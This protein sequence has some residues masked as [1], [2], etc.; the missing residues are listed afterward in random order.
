[1]AT[2]ALSVLA[3]ATTAATSP[4]STATQPAGT[5]DED[6][7]I[8]ASF[9][10]AIW[11]LI[12]PFLV[13]PSAIIGARLLKYGWK[14][15]QAKKYGYD[16]DLFEDPLAELG[17]KI[18]RGYEN[19]S[20]IRK[21]RK[22]QRKLRAEMHRRAKQNE[23]A[24]ADNMGDPSGR[25]GKRAQGLPRS[26]ST[27]IAGSFVRNILPIQAAETYL[28]TLRRQTRRTWIDKLSPDAVRRWFTVSRFARAWMVFQVFCTVLAI[29]NYVMLTYLVHREDRG[30]RKLI[31]NLD[32][33]YAAV[34]LVDYSLSFY[35]AEDRLRFYF[36]Y[37]SLV[38]LVSIVSPFVF[39][40]VASDT[41]FVWFVGLIRIFL[42]RDAE[43]TAFI[44][45]F[46]NFI[47][48]SASVINATETLVMQWSAP[49]SLL[50]W[51][52]SLYYIMVTF[53]TIGFGDLTPT[54]TISRIITGKILELYNSLSKYQRAAHQ[55]SS[56]SPHVILSG[57]VT[58][59]GL[60]DFCREYFISDNV[61]TIV[62]LH[63]EEPNIDIRRLLNHPFYRNRL[64]YLRGNLMSIPDLRRAAAQYATGMFL[65]NSNAA[66]GSG[67]GSSDVIDE[68]EE[69]KQTRGMDAQVLMQALVAKNG[70]PGLPIFA[71]VQD[72]RSKELSGH[73]GCDRILCIDEI[74]MSLMAAN[75]VVP[76]I[77]TLI[78]NLIHSYRELENSTLPE[79]W[80][81]EYQGG[82]ANQVYSFKVPNGLV[83]MKF[84]DA[85]AEVYNSYGTI[86]I[87]LM[88]INA[89][90]NQNPVRMSMDRDYRIKNDDIAFCM[91]TGGDE[92]VLRICIHFKEV[93]KKYELDR[94]D[95]EA[96]MS[97][98]INVKENAHSAFGYA[99]SP[100]LPS[101][102]NTGLGGGNFRA[103]SSN[104]QEMPQSNSYENKVGSI[105]AGL[106]GHIVLCGHITARAV[107]Q[108]VISL[109]GVNHP[110]GTTA[111]TLSLMAA[112]ARRVP[113]VC[114]VETL[115]KMD[116]LGVWSD[117]LSYENVFIVQGTAIKRTS[118]L[119]AGVS[120]CARIVILAKPDRKDSSSSAN[121][122]IADG[123]SLF[124][125][126]MLQREWPRVR[127]LV[128]LIDGANVKYFS[129]R[130]LE[131]DTHNM[132]IQAILSNY[133]LSISDRL[134]LYRK[135]RTEHAEQSTIWYQLVQ[136]VFG[137]GDSSSSSQNQG[138]MVKKGKN[139][140][141][142]EGKG[143]TADGQGKT[144]GKRGFA[145]RSYTSASAMKPTTTQG[146][147]D[148]LKSLR[149]DDI[150]PDGEEDDEE[151]DNGGIGMSDLGSSSN[152]QA[153]PTDAGV[154]QPSEST[155]ASRA[156]RVQPDASPPAR[157]T[158]GTAT[159]D[160]S[161]KR[162][163]D[164]DRQGNTG[165]SDS[166]SESETEERET[167]PEVPITEAYLQRLLEEAEL[168]ESGLSPYPVYHFDRHFAAG[169]VS[170]S[171]FIHSLLC[172][173][174][175]RPYIV[176]VVRA[177]ILSVIHLPV[178]QECVN[179]PY[180]HAVQYYLAAGYVPI[181]LYR[182]GAAAE[183]AAADAAIAASTIMTSPMSDI[184][185]SATASTPGSATKPR[186][187][188]NR[189]SE[190]DNTPYVYTN[191][192][193]SDIVNE[194]DLIFA[195]RKGP[196]K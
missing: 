122:S 70:F 166:D 158:N 110:D 103:D 92:T 115:P 104:F 45:N 117:I 109:R 97:R 61:G 126:K 1:M 60:V 84:Y 121:N 114:L 123:N 48:F 191:C 139:R 54:S 183:Q 86:I 125:V 65:L 83:G 55:A 22:E 156:Q 193:P 82:V 33:L 9:D 24:L 101:L 102:L 159:G 186:V 15:Y 76:G 30:Q 81:Q 171:S 112:P 170:T 53:S 49:P 20:E 155:R 21:I 141:K 26:T 46:L 77:Q 190:S 93:Y 62:V 69:L 113:V 43:L 41:K 34:F 72:V 75:C 57:S 47:F 174:Y 176:D 196:S 143:E 38:D 42:R 189:M 154:S 11:A 149:A 4:A 175:M 134:E 13:I 66:E 27:N 153:Q 168:N 39:V 195:I 130:N 182:R 87:A 68:A 32:L 169:M 164:A 165:D 40:L 185:F 37:T 124:I 160:D 167:K 35:I 187:G 116:D 161:A 178:S 16:D 177:L 58:P 131:W 88:S 173:S 91:S 150:F 147:Y 78:L 18:R 63:T 98:V 107:R 145:M 152:A 108:F 95:L 192:R 56:S 184:P 96:E 85:A 163:T 162:T 12:C 138:G 180:I 132:R 67:S 23:M 181:G 120:T 99:S 172:Q 25:D 64:V 7:L 133:A 6:P 157:E 118:L 151:G 127:F 194:S 2:V 140:N 29:V 51:H 19:T 135:L 79:F 128:E 8:D 142:G 44:L 71:Q 105:P 144:S 188:T 137:P 80:M 100:S 106:A 94:R 146:D 119:H 111:H 17:L 3:S 59:S 90:F 179:K 129:E 5:I 31:K 74:K 14:I 50:N 28:A 89:G 52:D 10:V 73:C 148:A 136:L 36:H